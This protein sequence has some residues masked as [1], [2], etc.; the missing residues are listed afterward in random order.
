MALKSKIYLLLGDA[1]WCFPFGSFREMNTILSRNS[2]A[3][4]PNCGA[5]KKL[6]SVSKKEHWKNL[7]VLY[8]LN[9]PISYFPY[10]YSTSIPWV[11]L[12]ITILHLNASW[13]R[14][15]RVMLHVERG[16]TKRCRN[17]RIRISHHSR[18]GH[19]TVHFTDPMT[20]KFTLV[21]SKSQKFSASQ[22]YGRH[23]FSLIT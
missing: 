15:N 16:L 4:V 18:A 17:K 12:K 10:G 5:T 3:Y 21:I 9:I 1:S 23:T 8:H 6:A 22:K 19:T 11:S 2:V 7:S 20:H 13:K 14:L